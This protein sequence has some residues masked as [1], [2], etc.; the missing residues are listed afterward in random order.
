MNFV[1]ET[2]INLEPGFEAEG[3]FETFIEET[4]PNCKIFCDFP[5]ILYYNSIVELF[6][7]GI[8]CKDDHVL[9]YIN[10][11]EDESCFYENLTFKL[12]IKTPSNQYFHKENCRPLVSFTLNNESGF[13]YF[14]F[15][16]K[17]E[18][19]ETSNHII[20]EIYVNDCSSFQKNNKIVQSDLLNNEEKNITCYPNPNNGI[21]SIYNSEF[22][23]YENLIE[24]YDVLGNKILIT[25]M[26]SQKEEIDISTLSN[27]IYFIKIYTD[28]EKVIIK[29]IIIE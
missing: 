2:E 17:N 15:Y 28:Y 11:E 9:F 25:K 19:N 23:G 12:D 18:Y 29:N 8:I 10:I 4:E 26:K 14:D 13:Y 21:F 5:P 6:P 22:S 24:I 3:D 27:G 1:A 16:L 20:K 7:L